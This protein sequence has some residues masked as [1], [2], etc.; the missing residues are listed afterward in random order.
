MTT[1]STTAKK[2]RRAA[3]Q[4][5]GLCVT[6]GDDRKGYS[7][8]FCERCFG[9]E[10]RVR[11]ARRARYV[12]AGL[13]ANCGRKRDKRATKLGN[14]LCGRCGRAARRFEAKRVAA[15]LCRLCG[16]KRN[17]YTRNCDECQAAF[18]LKSQLRRG[19]RAWVPGGPGSPPKSARV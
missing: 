8:R 13:C 18:R 10:E 17:L 1:G 2:D 4:A 12:A 16:R 3:R 14:K 11:K 19:Y 5:A 9:Y 7:K 15:G 6:C